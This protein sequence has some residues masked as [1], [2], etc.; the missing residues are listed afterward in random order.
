MTWKPQPLF[1]TP[2]DPDQDPKN[3][4]TDQD[5]GPGDRDGDVTTPKK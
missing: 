3:P 1:A 5:K 4:D 2:S